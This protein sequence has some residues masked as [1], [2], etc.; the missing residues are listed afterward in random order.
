[1]HGIL[2]IPSWLNEPDRDLDLVKHIALTVGGDWWSHPSDPFARAHLSRQ[3]GRYGKK[4]QL[5]HVD[6]FLSPPFLLSGLQDR[7]KP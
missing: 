4:A 2:K 6:L 5:T 1:M 3:L 7:W